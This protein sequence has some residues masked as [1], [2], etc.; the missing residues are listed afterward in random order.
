[1]NLYEERGFRLGL[2]VAAALRDTDSIVEA[3][4]AKT[5]E[6]TRAHSRPS[7]A[8]VRSRRRRPGRRQRRTAATPSR[9]VR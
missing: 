5:T 4:P 9:A 1:M 3:S 7:T 6:V 2:A 8:E